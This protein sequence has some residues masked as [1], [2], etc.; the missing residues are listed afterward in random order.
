MN[1][2]ALIVSV[3]LACLVEAVEALTIV[4]AAGI[5]R[6]W[7]SALLGACAGVL[8]LAVI[9]AVLGPAVSAIPVDGLRLVIGGLLLIFG[10]RWLR[11]AVLRASGNKPLHDESLSFQST[12][13]S[14][15]HMTRQRRRN[16][17]DWYGFSLAFQGVVLE[18]LEVVFVVVTFGANEHRIVPAAVT[19]LATVAVVSLSGF[20][21]RKPLT[22]IPENTL[23]FVVGILLSAYGLFWSVEGAGGNWPGGDKSLLVIVA[24]LALYSAVLVAVFRRRLPDRRTHEGALP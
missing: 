10:L 14:A 2:S 20:A 12:L 18:G 4:L 13:A 24:A 8:C 1:D 5:A 19:A 15:Q 7:R 23:K 11:K 6:G 22:L 9:V 17:P 16:I 21:L 3:F